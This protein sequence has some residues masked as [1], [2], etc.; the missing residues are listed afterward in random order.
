MSNYYIEKTTETKEIIYMRYR[1]NGYNFKPKNDA[2][3]SFNLHKITV[4][5]PS[6]IDGILSQKVE[7]QISKIVRLVMYILNT[8]EDANPGDTMLAL[9][10]IARLRSVI[11]NRYQDFITQENET[12]FLRKLRILENELRAKNMAYDDYNFGGP[13]F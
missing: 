4:V 13:R 11:L 7:K 5:K 8:D 3:N 9:N 12:I 10:E 6:L 1:I 2:H